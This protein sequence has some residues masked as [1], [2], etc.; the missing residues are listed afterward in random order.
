MAIVVYDVALYTTDHM[1]DWGQCEWRKYL[2]S[3]T[4][5]KYKN[6]NYHSGDKQGVV[7]ALNTWFDVDHIPLTIDSFPFVIYNQIDTQDTTRA[8]LI[9][10]RTL[11]DLKNDTILSNFNPN[12]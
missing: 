8:K 9:L 11:D 10:H 2:N 12:M 5:I 6:L 3:L 7:D 1:Y 4:N